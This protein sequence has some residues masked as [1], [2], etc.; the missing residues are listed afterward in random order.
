M[1]RF[2]KA[3]GFYFRW[4]QLALCPNPLTR[5]VM[6]GLLAVPFLIPTAEF[7][8][9]LVYDSSPPDILALESLPALQGGL[10]FFTGVYGL[11][12]VVNSHPLC[13]SRYLNWLK[14][15]P[16]Q[17]GKPLPLH[18]IHI[19]W[20]DGII[21]FAVTSITA[22][23]NPFDFLAYE[24]LLPITIMMA[25]MMLLQTIACGFTE[26]YRY[27]YAVL[28]ILPFGLMSKHSIVIELSIVLSYIV[29]YLGTKSILSDIGGKES[30]WKLI[31]SPKSKVVFAGMNNKYVAQMTTSATQ[32]SW[33][34]KQLHQEPSEYLARFTVA[35]FHTLIAFS[36]LF[37][38]FLYSEKELR[39]RGDVAPL[40]LMA[41]AA[42]IGI[43]MIRF[44]QNRS[45][46]CKR[47]CLG[48]RFVDKVLIV[49][50]HDR[51]IIEPLL[52]LLSSVIPIM[53]GAYYAQEFRETSYFFMGLLI[54]IPLEIFLLHT[55]GTPARNV[56]YT[57][58][59]I[60]G[61][62]QMNNKLVYTKLSSP[63][64]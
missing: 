10:Y 37:T 32:T 63:G 3:I 47:F 22:L 53:L 29:S 59:Q 7:L 44:L 58:P 13:N 41:C 39:F 52:I 36:W 25:A 43:A 26:H 16:W 12:R 34:Y 60:I 51:L 48:K 54:G 42:S 64:E 55:F 24:W 46:L 21:V 45:V 40:A 31:K 30:L 56:F 1:N 27:V 11:L 19:T 15:S 61:P 8:C 9:L 62:G 5:V 20:Q 28:L 57:G 23:I 35:W 4:V 49:W 17:W 18:P 50:K 38:I 6:I 14:R 2:V 33:P